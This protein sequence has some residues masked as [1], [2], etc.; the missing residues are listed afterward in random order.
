MKKCLMLFLFA[1]LMVQSIGV[2]KA[3]DGKKAAAYA[4]KYWK[5]SNTNYH[6][7]KNDCT[8][9]VSQ[10]LVAGGLKPTAMPQAAINAAGI[11]AQSVYTT[12]KHRAYFVK[13]WSSVNG[14]GQKIGG[15]SI[16]ATKT[17][18]NVSAFYDYMTTY[19][20]VKSKTF[21]G[22]SKNGLTSLIKNSQVGD[23]LQFTKKVKGETIKYH[24]VIVISKSKNDIEIAYHSN[25]VKTSLRQRIKK[26]AEH[27]TVYL[28]KFNKAK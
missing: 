12:K 24:S 18:C 25:N 27:N 4:K 8:N 17:W 15:Y 23:V 13:H 10:C 5:K 7:Y 6:T 1:F 14:Y 26:L 28:L 21:N 3:Y 19:R 22:K 16:I 2:V 20:N 11:R 9:F